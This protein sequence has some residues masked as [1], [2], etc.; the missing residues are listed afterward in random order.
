MNETGFNSTGTIL[1]VDPP[2]LLSFAWHE[3]EGPPSVVTFELEPRGT[4]VLLT[5]THSELRDRAMM[6]DVSGGWHSHLAQLVDELA[7]RPRG[8]FWGRHAE[9]EGVYEKRLPA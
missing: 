4:E 2:R 6:V 7:G 1:K 3:E 5:L 9:L 8:P